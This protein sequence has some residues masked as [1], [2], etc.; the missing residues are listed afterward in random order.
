[1]LLK[2][3]I[4]A[5]VCGEDTRVEAMRVAGFSPS[6]DQSYVR[7]IRIDSERDACPT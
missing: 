7:L 6:L 4:T 1:M 5:L 2:L 3:F